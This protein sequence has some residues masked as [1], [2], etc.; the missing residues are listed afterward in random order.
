MN[1]EMR[2]DTPQNQ[3]VLNI[4][5][6]V[7]LYSPAGV[8]KINPVIN[9]SKKPIMFAGHSFTTTEIT[10]NDNCHLFEICAKTFEFGIRR[11]D[12]TMTHVQVSLKKTEKIW[13]FQV[14]IPNAQQ[15]FETKVWFTEE[16]NI[17][18]VGGLLEM[19]DNKYNIDLEWDNNKL[20]LKEKANTL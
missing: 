3:D 13:L 15:A 1:F 12:P 19:S 4:R 17:Y 18:T 14:A 10:E 6:E 20:E 11:E 9:N 7:T 5:Q 2:I 16:K 8:E